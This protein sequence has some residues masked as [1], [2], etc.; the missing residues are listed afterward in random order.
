[1]YSCFDKFCHTYWLLA[2]GY[3]LI[4]EETNQRARTLKT[5]TV[6]R[7]IDPSARV[8]SSAT[9]GPYC[10]VG[11]HVTIGPDTVLQRRACVIGHTII[12]QGNVIGEG[13]VLGA[14][15]QDLKYAGGVTLLVIGHRNRFGRNVTAHIG[16]ESGGYLTRIGDGNLLKDGCHVGHDSFI[17]DRA[18]LGSQVLLAGHIRVHE[19]AVLEDLSAVLQFCTIGQYARVGRRVPVRRDVPPYTNFGCRDDDPTTP[20]VLGI[21][22]AGIAAAKRLNAEDKKELRRALA[23]LFDNEAALATKIEQL[24]NLGVDGEVAALCDFCKRSLQGTYG[25]HREMYRG[26]VPPEV[27]QF[28]PTEWKTIIRRAKT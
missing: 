2:I 15:P 9:I 24:V 25:R 20:E 7:E 12:G 21:H 26:I 13:C 17:D 22:E 10:V 1:V 8:A 28:I 6:F 14:I 19:G 23:D 27:E 3:W 11:P 18:T 16:T 5:V 4:N